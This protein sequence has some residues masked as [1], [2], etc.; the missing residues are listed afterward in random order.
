MAIGIIPH[1]SALFSTEDLTNE[2][3]LAL[4]TEAAKNLGWELTYQGRDGFVAYTKFRRNSINE[5]ITMFIEGGLVTLKSES[6]G[7]QFFDRGQNKKNIDELQLG[8]DN[9]KFSLNKEELEA[10][11]SQYSAELIPGSEESSPIKNSLDATGKSKGFLSVFIPVKGYTVTPILININILIFILMIIS[12]V[13]IMTPDNESILHW[14]ANFRPYTLN[15]EPWRLLTNIFLHIGMLHLAFNMYALLFIGVLLEPLLGSWRFGITYLLTGIIASI[16]SLYWH[17][18]TISAGASGA[19]FGMYGVYLAMLTTNLIEKERRKALLTSIAIFVGYNLLNGVNGSI[20]SAAHIGGLV[21][22]IIMG[23]SFYPGLNNPQDKKLNYGLPAILIIALVIFSSWEYIRIP[24]DIIQ[25][26]NGIE[27][28]SINESKALEVY[29]MPRSTPKEI[30]LTEIKDSGLY[31]WNQDKNLLTN[32]DK[33]NLPAE[34]HNRNKSLIA[35]CDFRISS[36]QLMYKSID[37]NTEIYIGQLKDYTY[38]I[39]SLLKELKH[40]K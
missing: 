17:P 12:G 31:Y 36:F 5:K 15:G 16:T 34:I 2:Q 40:M 18:V 3:Y 10:K 21:S 29:K 9:L 1:H 8:F 20:D 26:Q 13:G 35:Y 14:G 7:G 32:L 23:Y 19:I 25:Y 22:G 11:S 24:R 38:S 37:E 27:T 39:D 28:F 30:L 33:L 6:Q 4:V